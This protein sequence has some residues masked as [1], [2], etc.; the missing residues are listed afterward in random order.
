[1]RADSEY[2]QE[3][4]AINADHRRITEEDVLDATLTVSRR[5]L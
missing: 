5:S 2:Q 4:A 1:M 3:V